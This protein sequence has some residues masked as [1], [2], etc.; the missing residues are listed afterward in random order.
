[1]LLILDEQ[2]TLESVPRP[3]KKR[4][5]N[6]WF[7]RVDGDRQAIE[8]ELESYRTEGGRVGRKDERDRK[9][10]R[11]IS[12]QQICLG[13]GPRGA[14]GDRSRKKGR[15]SGVPSQHTSPNVQR[16]AAMR[17]AG[18]L[19]PLPKDYILERR[20][21]AVRAIAGPAERR[22]GGKSEH[23]RAGRSITWSRGDAKESATESKP[24]L[25]SRSRRACR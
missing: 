22:F 11:R 4:E 9:K 21:G 17:Q 14:Y 7:A 18:I 1:M 6:V 5:G 19:S 12:V 2:E 16:V 10:D 25:A 8:L 3:K 15:L 13:S 20:V 23:R 24:P